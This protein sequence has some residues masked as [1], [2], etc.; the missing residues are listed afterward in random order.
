[1]TTQDTAFEGADLPR[2]G[3]PHFKAD[4]HARYA[5]LRQQHGPILAARTSDGTV[6]WL[7]LGYELAR[8]ALAHP[9]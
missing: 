6:S 9:N 1:M 7:V 4:P 3:Q 8:E 2:V 5:E